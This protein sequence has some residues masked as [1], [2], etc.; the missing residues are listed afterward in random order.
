MSDIFLSYKNEDK[1][2][3]QIIAEALEQKGYSV[4]WDKVIPP[5][6]TFDE[7]IKEE[8]DSA[9]CVLV[10]WS[11]KSVLSDWVKE[12]ADIG[13]K[14]RI[15]VPILIDD[16]EMPMGF[17]RIQAARLMDWHGT[18]PNPEFDL[19]LNSVAKIV[20]HPPTQKTEIKKQS[21]NEVDISAAQPQEAKR[22]EPK[23]KERHHQ[24]EEEINEKE[25]LKAGVGKE[26][27]NYKK[28][29]ILIAVL[30]ILLVGY[31]IYPAQTTG[32][33]SVSSSPSGAGIYLDG[34][35][36]GTTPMTIETVSAGSHIVTL[37]LTDYQDLSQAISAK[38]GEIT[39]FSLSL[40]ST[41]TLP[42]ALTNSIGIEF[43][44]IPSGE[45]DM[46]SPASEVGRYDNEGP[47][48]Q[49]KLAN[50][51]Y[52][53]K[54][55]VTQKQWREIMGNDP[56]YYKGD[57][58]PVEQVSW[59]DV[60]D[61]IKKLNEKEGGGKYRLPSEAEWEYAARAGTTTRYS[62]GDDE[63]KLGD[64][65]WYYAQGEGKTHDVGQKKPNPWGLYDMLGNVY[66]WVQDSW[67]SD[68]NGAP[69]DG[70]SWESLVD[71]TRVA[72]G[73]AFGSLASSSRSAVRGGNSPGGRYRP[74]GFRLVRVL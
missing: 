68:Y 55:E 47:V 67:H 72:R 27:T 62:F 45:F 65:E 70:S 32:S 30:G 66:E 42:K 53:G 59:N 9:K 15:L 14:R 28:P 17:G 37:N 20:G 4:W 52:M 74:L 16:V 8:L 23:K 69:I 38:A 58:L 25:E 46:G 44:L 11:K 12:E 1:A 3:A 39:Y 40:T 73:G 2:K 48:H 29:L 54:Y 34:I 43:V 22:V 57:N 13:K 36:R 56:S 50:A 10:L 5:G 21:K 33:I 71:S 51:F 35:Y 6:R 26:K 63:S 7:I 49:V 61:F 64:Y 24:E 60:Q 18:L 31:L 19:L 41:F